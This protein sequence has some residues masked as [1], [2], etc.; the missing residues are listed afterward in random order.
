MSHMKS[1]WLYPV[2]FLCECWGCAHMLLSSPIVIWFCYLHV[3]CFDS[4]VHIE[5]GTK[6]LGK[7]G[8]QSWSLAVAEDLCDYVGVKGFSA[9][10]TFLLEAQDHTSFPQTNN[11]YLDSSISSIAQSPF[12]WISLW[13]IIQDH[14]FRGRFSTFVIVITHFVLFYPCLCFPFITKYTHVPFWPLH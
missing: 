3:S 2:T 10:C 5:G 14:V 6:K 8:W 12:Q 1:N 9:F 4:R 13:R 11:R 7:E